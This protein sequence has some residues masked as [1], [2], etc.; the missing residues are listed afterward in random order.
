LYINVKLEGKDMNRHEAKTL[1]NNNQLSIG[2]WITIGHPAI[3][4]ILS[5]AGFDW[6]V[7]DLEHTTID[8]S[9]AQILISTIQSKNMLALVR[10]SKNEEVIIKRVLDAG[11]D[12]IVVPM[13]KNAVD[14]QR[15]VNY[16]MYPP[17]GTRGVGLARAQNY[18]YGFSKYQEKVNETII[19]AQIEHVDAINELDSILKVDGIAGTIIGPYD[20]SGS[21]GLPGDF[22]NESVKN[23]LDEY[24]RVS[25][26]MDKLMGFH[27][28]DSNPELVEKKI[29]EGYRF[30]AYGTDFLFMGDRAIEGMLNLRPISLMK[31]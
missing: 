7:I 15:A 11:A 3:P 10:V 21:L 14:A 22:D 4:E 17:I 25:I 18:G 8:L 27:V 2:S 19:I 20:L 13:V 31:D 9:M 5:N 6:L 12:G 29:E 16:S 28:V 1:V 26:E 23:L 24:K 30:I